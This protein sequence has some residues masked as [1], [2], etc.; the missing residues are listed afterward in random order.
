MSDVI[1][2]S[3]KLDDAI[4][5]TTYESYHM[6]VGDGSAYGAEERQHFYKL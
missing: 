3:L 2:S 5:A 1:I 6:L 4:K